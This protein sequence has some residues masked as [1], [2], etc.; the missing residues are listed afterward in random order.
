MNNLG[1]TSSR[2]NMVD[3]N[4]LPERHR[5]R[6]IRTL[7]VLAFLL[8]AILLGLLYPAGKNFWSAQQEY[9]S[10]RTT[11][12]RLKSE[13]ENYQPVGDRLENL[14]SMI[15]EANQKAESIRSTLTQVQYDQ[16]KWS[17][18][19]SAAWESTPQGVEIGNLNQN[20]AQIEINGL[21]TSY[22]RVLDF[23]ENLEKRGEFSQTEILSIVFI[24][25][26]DFSDVPSPV[27]PNSSSYY[28]FRIT[29]NTGEED[30]QP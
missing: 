11:F 19:L 8:W 25:E 14:Q 29:V 2:E 10:Q 4:V 12:S 26:E 15:E 3:L 22:Q 18:L 5:K 9:T 27:N 20:K 24:A 30:N 6:R 23:R 28:S 1:N 16:T 21:S 17:K 13:V 7:G